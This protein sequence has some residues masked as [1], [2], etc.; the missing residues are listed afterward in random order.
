MI[1]ACV[2]PMQS[3]H[4][5]AALASVPCSRAILGLRFRLSHAVVPSLGCACVCPMQS[6]HPWA[7]LHTSPMPMRRGSDPTLSRF[8]NT[9]TLLFSRQ[10]NSV[11]S[12]M[13]IPPNPYASEP[14]STV[15]S[16]SITTPL[17]YQVELRRAP[18]GGPLRQWRHG[19]VKVDPLAPLQA[20]ER[21]LVIR[22]YGRTSGRS[23]RWSDDSGSDEDIEDALVRTGDGRGWGMRKR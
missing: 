3:C 17:L 8:P 19:P 22:G 18:D 1:C 15:P 7:G 14:T 13:L 12:I 6:C 11:N 21:Y 2:C 5:R 10:D 9:C 20:I 4:P 16:T 23:S